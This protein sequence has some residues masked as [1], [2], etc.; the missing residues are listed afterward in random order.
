MTDIGDNIGRVRARIA[1]AAVRSGRAPDS[2]T[3]VAVTK[4]VDVGRIREAVACGLRVF[5]ENRVQEARE[6]VPHFP[7]VSWHLIGSLQRNKVREAVRLFH[8]IHSVD[9]LPLAEEIGRRA[10]RDGAGRPMEILVQVNVSEEPHKHG[11]APEEVGDLVAEVIRVPGLRPRG[12]MG[13]APLVPAADQARPYFRRLREIRDRL[14]DRMPQAV[15]PD[16]SMGM[17]DDFEVAIEEGATLVRIGR[18]LFASP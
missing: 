15:L 1:D 16:L 13:I 17:S 10:L 9:S 14:R 6:K 5:G 8:L 7:D 3:L 18:A 11:I 4:T 2:V 12:L